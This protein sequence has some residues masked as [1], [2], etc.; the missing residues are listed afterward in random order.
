MIDERA[1]FRVRPRGVQDS[2]PRD[3]G[4]EF[5]TGDGAGGRALDGRAA[6][7]W[8]WPYAGRPLTDSGPC[9]PE[10]A[11]YSRMATSECTS[12]LNG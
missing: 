11:G 10:C 9:N 2:D 4:A 3:I 12:M 6:L 1:P 8:D 5:L 7:F